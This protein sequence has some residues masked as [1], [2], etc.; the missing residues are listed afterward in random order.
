[1]TERRLAVLVALLVVAAVVIPYTLLSNV[2]RVSGAF[3]FWTQFAL[4]VIV[5]IVRATR[6]WQR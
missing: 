1:M 6:E 3:L 2:Q 4:V 5:L